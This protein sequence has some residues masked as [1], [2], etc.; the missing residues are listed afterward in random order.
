MPNN[1][2]PALVAA[3]LILSPMAAF[4]D[5]ASASEDLGRVAANDAAPSTDPLA[6][7]PIKKKLHR[8]PHREKRSGRVTAKK[9]AATAPGTPKPIP[10][11]ASH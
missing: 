7:K 6:P 8:A 5:H 9:D 4:A 11:A 10:A 1:F 3:A 2:V